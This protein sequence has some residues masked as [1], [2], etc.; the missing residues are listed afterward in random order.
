MSIHTHETHKGCTST[1]AEVH[2]RLQRNANYDEGTV[3]IVHGRR[4]KKTTEWR[5]TNMES[6]EHGGGKIFTNG[7]LAIYMTCKDHDDLEAHEKPCPCGPCIEDQ[8][9]AFRC[10]RCLDTGWTALGAC[11]CQP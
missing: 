8:L 9:A 1:P 5:W 2:T 11:S 3:L 6:E 4:I 7:D 10:H